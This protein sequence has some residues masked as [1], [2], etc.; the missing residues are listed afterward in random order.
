MVTKT[1]DLENWCMHNMIGLQHGMCVEHG[2][3]LVVLV[4]NGNDKNDDWLV[5]SE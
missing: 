5:V 4:G 2:G 3:A 1:H